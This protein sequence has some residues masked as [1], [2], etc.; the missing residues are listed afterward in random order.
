MDV[1]TKA[2]ARATGLKYYF[3]GVACKRGHIAPRFLCGGCTQCCAEKSKNWYSDKEKA[4]AKMRKWRSENKEQER[5]TRV[6]WHAANPGK[7]AEYSKRHRETNPDAA[8][9]AWD[10][11]YQKNIVAQRQRAIVYRNANIESARAKSS[12]YNRSNPEKIA[13][14]KRN[15]RAR[16]LGGGTHTERDVAEIMKMQKGKCA[17]C[18]IGLSGKYHVD[19]IVALKNGGSNRRSN[20][21]ILCQPCN[22]SKSAKDPIVFAQSLG[23]LL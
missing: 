13:A 15:R 20:L 2:E 5:A 7:T 9:A 21:Q 23:M 17:Y 8:K 14:H 11:W 18:R 16:E 3:T 19:H 12:A 4:A 6:A 1:C 22:Q 10:R